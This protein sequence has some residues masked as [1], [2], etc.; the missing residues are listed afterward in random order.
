M[1]HFCSHKEILRFAATSK[2]YCKVIANSVSLQLHIELEENGLEIITGTRKGNATYSLLLDELVRYRDAWLNLM[3][4]KPTQQ[5]PMERNPTWRWELR[6][7]SYAMA[8]SSAPSTSLDPDSL[9]VMSLDHLNALNQVTF[10]G[11]FHDFVSSLEQ[12]LVVLVRVDP[13]NHSSFDVRFCS[14]TTGL[15]HPLARSHTLSVRVD[16]P[17]P[18]PEEESEVFT[19]AIMDNIFVAGA[20]NFKGK[21]EI[22]VWDWKSGALLLRIG[23]SS[24]LADCSFLG[25][26]HLVVFSV[27]NP[28]LDSHSITLSL[29]SITPHAYDEAPPGSH[30]W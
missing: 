25:K 18:H 27:D 12:D 11:H 22:L 19:L 24:G 20:S 23:S 29:Y 8:F 26:T 9:W 28:E 3:F 21:C 15:D 17:L 30:F 2:R 1:L 5:T 14:A 4:E 13:D 10:Q 6:E 16:F 7:G